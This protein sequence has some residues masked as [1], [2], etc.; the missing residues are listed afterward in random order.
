M[1]MYNTSLSIYVYMSRRQP[2]TL[3]QAQTRVHHASRRSFAEHLL[4]ATEQ[5]FSFAEQHTISAHGWDLGRK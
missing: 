5:S 1:Y 3:H 4:Q 2:N